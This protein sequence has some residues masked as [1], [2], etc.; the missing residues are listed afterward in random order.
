MWVMQSA[1]LP[2]PQLPRRA[3]G[4]QA[5]RCAALCCQRDFGAFAGPSAPRAPGPVHLP[6][7]QPPTCALLLQLVCNWACVAPVWPLHSIA[8]LQDVQRAD[9]RGHRH[10]RPPRLQDHRRQAHAQVG[11]SSRSFLLPDS[12]VPAFAAAPALTGA[13]CPGQSWAGLGWRHMK[14]CRAMWQSHDLTWP[15]AQAGRRLHWPSRGSTPWC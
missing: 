1:L 14:V 11:K 4:L 15:H 6:D 12:T 9:Q 3:G 13:A 10:G 5:R 8:T 7:M 2:Q